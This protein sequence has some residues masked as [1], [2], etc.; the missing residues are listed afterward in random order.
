[1]AMR[2]NL[3]TRRK[4]LAL[5]AL[6]PALAGLALLA[7]APGA[8][9]DIDF[10]PAGEGAGQ[11]AVPQHLNI[12]RG[13][14]FDSETGH[15][16]VADNENN[17]ID[18]FAEDGSFLFAFGWKVNAASPEEKLQTCT[19]AT[20]CQKG[21]P[22]AGAG[23]FNNPTSVAVDNDPASSS[24]HDLYVGEGANLRVQKFNSGGEFIWTVGKGVDKTEGANLCTQA[25]GHTCGAGA[26]GEVEGTF[27]SPPFLGVGPGGALYALDSIHVPGPG[28]VHQLRLQRFEASGAPIPSQAILFEGRGEIRGIAVDAAGDAWVSGGGGA[29]GLSKYSPSGALLA[30]PIDTEIEFRFAL[31]TD[32][33]GDVY[34]GQRI[35]TLNVVSAYGPAGN[36]LRRFAYTASRDFGLINGLAAHSG[37]FGDVAISEAGKEVPTRIRYVPLP[38]PG[39]IA[40]AATVEAP[41]A[42]IGSTKATVV[43]EVNPE[44][45]PTEVHFEYLSQADYEQQGDSFAGP[46]TKSTPT[47][48]LGAEGFSLKATEATLGCP[49]PATEAAEPGNDCLV[50][51]TEY[52]Y[53]V[54]ATNGDG[55]GEGTAEGVPFT[56]AEP[57]EFGATYATEVGT[58]VARLHAEVNP[59]GVSASGYF[60]Y[61]DDARFQEDLANGGDGFAAATEAPDVEAGQA[62]LEF[63]SGDALAGRAVTLYPLSPGTTYHYRLIA[64]DLLIGPRAGEAKTLRTFEPPSP[65]PCPANEAFRTG[66]AALLPD[67]RAYELV[68]P[69]EKGGDD[70]RVL[71]ASV[72]QVPAVLEQSSLTGD[73][74]AF[75]STRAFGDAVSSPLTS[76]YIAER[77]A[78][79]AWTTHAISPPRGVSLVGAIAQGDTEFKFFSPD[80]CQAWLTT[81]AEPPLGEGARAGYSNLYRRSDRLCG[82]EGYRAL[83]PI[84]EPKNISPGRDFE[85]ELQGVAADGSDAIFTADAELEGKGSPGKTQLYEWAGGPRPR[86]VCVLPGG[87]AW[88][89]PCEAGS[90]PALETRGASVAGAISEDGQR[91]YWS[92]GEGEGRLYVRIG[93]A[94]TVAVSEAA[95]AAQGTS[96]SYFRGASSDGGTAIFTTGNFE[97]GKATLYSFTLEGNATHPIAGGVL[98][99]M[100][101]SRDAK[102][103]YFASKEALAGAAIAGRPNLYLY[104]AGSGGAP[105]FIGTLSDADASFLNGSPLAP[106]PFKR[107]SR[108]SPDGAHAAFVSS[109]SLTGYDNRDAKGGEPS[110]EVYL[111]DAGT[112]KLRCLSCN[113]SGAR[114]AG[115]SV[116]PPFETTMHASQAFSDDG[117]R[118]FFESADALTPRDTNGRKD[119]YEWEAPGAGTC[120]TAS[121]SYSSQDIGCIDL[122]SSGQSPVDSRFVEADPSGKDVFFAT[123]SSLLPQ[124]YGLIDIYDARVEG[125][126]PTPRPT[127]PSCEGE[128]CQGPVTPPN[129]PTPASSAFHGAGNVVK[130]KRKHRKAHRKHRKKAHRAKHKRANHNGR[131]GR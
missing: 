118:L 70:I 89:G 29:A 10:C 39:P 101:M 73:K 104:E 82:E 78:G 34:A 36:V 58:D 107:I 80:L 102:R 95:E 81:Y 105:A 40:V 52:R 99:V 49:D 13:L 123:Q 72:A 90:G 2:R 96:S 54:V 87:A 71:Q 61:V 24:R 125:G 97:E 57:L 115:P 129:D 8:Q 103:V 64:T 109:A 15:L 93:G 69:L 28:E 37:P 22:G 7:L 60:E 38:P 21:T 124:D 108:V 98:G 27:A 35:G 92:T 4:R 56:T 131:A 117:R 112:A 55:A 67:C 110:Q 113:P 85:M 31:T 66:A 88:A 33:S 91:I 18:V 59:F 1:M 83:A 94:Q 5:V 12:L 77:I 84:V 130:A 122:I 30:G 45:K 3:I 41:P 53:R 119:V 6:A 19:T 63:G 42:G 106:L 17:R 111:Y 46:A 25:S 100:G 62:P 74:L 65:L 16:Y 75:G 20:G 128:A 86:F 43:A 79:S 32:P 68:S 121:V 44:G 50:P 127:P 14:A 11:C 116:I 51:E 47:V 114:P 23:Q 76:Q 48:P 120:T 9:A 26:E 126:L